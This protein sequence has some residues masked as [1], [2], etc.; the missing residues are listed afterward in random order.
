M[1]SEFINGE[2]GEFKMKTNELF[3]QIL[4]TLNSTADT[5]YESRQD[6]L[7]ETVTDISNKIVA[8]YANDLKQQLRIQ[9]ADLKVVISPE[10]VVH[11]TI[12]DEGYRLGITETEQHGSVRF[13]VIKLYPIAALK[14]VEKAYFIAEM[15]SIKILLLHSLC[16]EMK[17]A[18]QFFFNDGE[19]HSTG[20][21]FS[22]NPKAY[23]ADPLEFEA[24]MFAREILQKRGGDLVAI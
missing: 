7:E 12:G 14:L 18:Q 10:I 9:H 17:H 22:I 15:L 16:H 6:K 21:L 20:D 8:C 19:F 24:D 1:E 3:G 11:K 5:I 4:S 13:A 23:A 2:Q